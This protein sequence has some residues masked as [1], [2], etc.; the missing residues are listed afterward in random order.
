MSLASVPLVVKKTRA[1]GMGTREAI[2][3]AN[4]TCC[5]TRYRV[6]EWMIRSAWRRI[7][8]TTAGT[9]WPVM[10]VRIPPK[11]SRYS[12][13]AASRTRRPSPVDQGDGVLVVQGQ[14]IRQHPPVPCQE[15]L[16]VGHRPSP[17]GIPCVCRGTP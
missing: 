8:S 10:V 6:E 5:G 2:R 11:K 16:F 1:S 4:S 12:F 14:P 7:A 13:P 3:S 9:R 15:C 17:G